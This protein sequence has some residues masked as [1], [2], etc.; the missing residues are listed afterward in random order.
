MKVLNFN[1][2]EDAQLLKEVIIESN[3]SENIR[4]ATVGISRINL[5]EIKTIP[6]SFNDSDSFLR[7][8]LM[9]SLIFLFWLTLKAIRFLD[10]RSSF[11]AD[12]FIGTLVKL[13]IKNKKGNKTP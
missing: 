1:L 11:F 6:L 5:K 4:E 10:F 13:N 9:A 12:F 7:I 3:K 2:V 8:F